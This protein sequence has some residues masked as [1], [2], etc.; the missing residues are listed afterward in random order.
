MGRFREIF[1]GRMNRAL[2]AQIA[3]QVPREETLS[4]I[5]ENWKEKLSSQGGP[6]NIEEETKG[7]VHRLKKS[8]YMGVFKA[9]GISERDLRDTLVQAVEEMGRTNLS[10]A[11]KDLAK[12]GELVG[13]GEW[14]TVDEV[15]IVP[16]I[17]DKEELVSNGGRP[18]C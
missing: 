16:A 17:V 3:K 4:E 7:M 14:H 15:E 6:V 11:I 10:Q 12:E 13:N 18:G 9:A 5:K 1:S 2:A 8:K